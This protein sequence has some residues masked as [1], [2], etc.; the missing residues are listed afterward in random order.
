M[1]ML[2]LGLV[3]L[4]LSASTPPEGWPVAA[5][6]AH[7]LVIAVL[8]A[9]AIRVV[10]NWRRVPMFGLQGQWVI[11]SSV[12][13]LFLTQAGL[14]G[15]EARIATLIGL[16]P[17]TRHVLTLIAQP[18]L[19]LGLWLALSSLPTR[20]SLDMPA[21][22]DSVLGAMTELVLPP[23]NRV[24]PAPGA[25]NTQTGL[26]ADLRAALGKI[27]DEHKLL[28][29][30]VQREPTN[31]AA[32]LALHRRLIMFPDQLEACIAHAA[33][34]INALQSS[35][36]GELRLKLAEDCA[37]MSPAYYPPNVHTLALA[38]QA[39]ALGRH[40]LAL[41]LL[42]R[43]DVRNP[44]HPDIP[45]TLLLSAQALGGMGR[46]AQAQALLSALVQNYP[47]S[48]I[49]ADAIAL[50]ARVAVRK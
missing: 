41:R 32:R 49:A 12:L 21:P 45:N 47:N 24:R 34:F 46:V 17:I 5:S 1:I 4:L 50:S 42:S 27:S 25:R 38:Q 14:P 15:Q 36:H 23:G 6:W 2:W 9:A 18:A 13:T 31:I 44:G 39:I 43:F 16:D 22:P 8:C 20:R 19:L 28:R 10:Q 37:R 40:P 3:T 48:D 35:D 33:E 29:D 7:I 11:L 26:T 30:K